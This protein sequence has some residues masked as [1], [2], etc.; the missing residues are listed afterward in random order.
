MEQGMFRKTDLEAFFKALKESGNTLGNTLGYSYTAHAM[1]STTESRRSEPARVAAEEPTHFEHEGESESEA[2]GLGD[3]GSGEAG[4]LGNQGS[5]SHV[6]S[7]EESERENQ[8][9]EPAPVAA[10]EQTHFEHEGGSESEAEGLGDQGSGEA[11][12]L[13]NQGSDSPVQSGEESGKR[14]RS[15]LVRTVRTNKDQP[16]LDQ[17]KKREPRQ[18][19][20]AWMDKALP[21]DALHVWSFLLVLV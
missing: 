15:V 5:D 19:G 4:G 1:S 9:E 12:D 16:K 7:G 14:R 8:N 6:Q 11:G 10:E 17:R 21:K 2:G 20:T 18:A 3:Q 13:G